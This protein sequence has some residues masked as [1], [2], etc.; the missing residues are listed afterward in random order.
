MN[1]WENDPD[2]GKI[3]WMETSEEGNISGTWMPPEGND[4]EFIVGWPFSRKAEPSWAASMFLI[5]PKTNAAQLWV[6]E[7]V[8]VADSYRLGPC[9]GVGGHYFSDIVKGIGKSGLKWQA[10]F[11]VSDYLGPL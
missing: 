7:N 9:F 11:N 2:W 5:K 10:D 8:L 4:F 1:A 3:H 6:D